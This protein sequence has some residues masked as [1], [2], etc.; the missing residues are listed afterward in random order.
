MEIDKEREKGTRGRVK[1]GEG[2]GG[3]PVLT[4]V[5]ARGLTHSGHSTR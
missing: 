1:G 5:Y 2:G 4:E 3:Q